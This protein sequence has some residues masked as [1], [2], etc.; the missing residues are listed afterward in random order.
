ML[1]KQTYWHIGNI[2][3]I[4]TLDKRHMGRI[5]SRVYKKHRHP[6]RKCNNEG[7]TLWGDQ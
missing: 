2:Q 3:S 4:D 7:R 6:E 1:G 5:A